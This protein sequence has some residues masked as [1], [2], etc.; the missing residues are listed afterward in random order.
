MK[1][2]FLI[3]GLVILFLSVFYSSTPSAADVPSWWIGPESEYE[4]L[5]REAKKEGELVVWAHPDPSCK[6]LFAGPFEQKY[7]IAVE[8]T[9]YTTAQ[10]VQRILLE[11]VAGMYTVDIG[12]LSVH[13]VPRLE[14]KGLL[15]QLPYKDRVSTYRKIPGLVSPN[16]TAVIA[17]TN[18]RSLAF[19]T[20]KIPKDK[21]PQS[22]EDVLDPVFANRKISIDTDL[23]EYIILA[24]EWGMEKTKRYLRDL[25]EMRP[26]YHPNNTVITQM[27]AA[28]EAIVGP[29]V[30]HRIPL[31]EFKA[32]GAPIDWKPLKP[33][34]PLDTMLMGVMSHAP[35]PHAAALFNYWMMGAPDYLQGMEK[36]SGYGHAMIPGNFQQKELA[37]VKAVPFDWEW[38]VKAAKEHYGEQ[39]RRIIG[40]E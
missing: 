37:E 9:E 15:Q 32:K 19:N 23:K 6:S 14:K 40:I 2:S 22:Y 13:H 29:G 16:S 24:Q 38:G 11:G 26:K 31:F 36:C 18:P 4:T 30:I 27:I 25:G 17:Y 10:I 21:I 1:K 8:H 34:V 12:N 28:G 5:V 35:H 20:R 33:I 39:F 7:G 3:Q